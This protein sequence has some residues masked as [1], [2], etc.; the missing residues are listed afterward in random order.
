[1]MIHLDTPQSLAAER[2]R[3]AA[4]RARA[5]RQRARLATTVD[6]IVVDALADGMHRLKRGTSVEE[7]IRDVMADA[8]GRLRAA[9]I[10]KPK[11]VLGQR[12]GLLRQAQ[13]ETLS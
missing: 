1:M 7:L 12:M 13:N 2:Q 9:G 8:L 4:A 5:Y 11:T 3:Q 10:E 6:E